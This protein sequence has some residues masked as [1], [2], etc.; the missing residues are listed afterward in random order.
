[1]LRDLRHLPYA[2][3]C[4]NS[5]CS[6]E[7]L[8]S[9]LKLDAT[10]EV[11]RRLD[12][13]LDAKH[14]HVRKKSTELLYSIEQMDRELFRVYGAKTIHI[15]TVQDWSQDRQKRHAT[16]MD[17]RLKQLLRHYLSLRGIK[18]RLPDGLNYWRTKDY[19]KRKGIDLALENGNARRLFRANPMVESRFL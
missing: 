7:Q 9:A 14:L 2:H 15:L 12:A 8:T 17:Y 18:A 16:A 19:L 1:M 5:R 4:E 3:I 11:L 13:Y 10:E 6:R